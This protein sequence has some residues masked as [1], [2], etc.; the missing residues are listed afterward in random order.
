MLVA[1]VYRQEIWRGDRRVCNLPKLGLNPLKGVA[2]PTAAPR[3]DIADIHPTPDN[4]YE[5]DLLRQKIL[6]Y[7]IS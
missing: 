1:D 3:E 5:I 6:S 4:F 2:N 7:H